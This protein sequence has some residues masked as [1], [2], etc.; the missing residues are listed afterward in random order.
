M[1]NDYQ[2]CHYDENRARHDERQGMM[3]DNRDEIS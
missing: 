1:V 3:R 2:Y